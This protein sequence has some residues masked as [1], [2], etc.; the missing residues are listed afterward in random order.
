MDGTSSRRTSASASQ[1]WDKLT[2]RATL[3]VLDFMASYKTMLFPAGERQS[4]ALAVKYPQFGSRI[5]SVWLAQRK[6]RRGGG[7]PSELIRR[8]DPPRIRV[9]H[10]IMQS[11]MFCSWGGVSPLGV[12]YNQILWRGRYPASRIPDLQWSLQLAMLCRGNDLDHSL[13]VL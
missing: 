2:T 13:N 5:D 8:Q 9:K 10:D 7:S 11:R 1:D 3:S 4:T 6:L 12:D